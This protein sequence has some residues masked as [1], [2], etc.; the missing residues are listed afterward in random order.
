V[1]GPHFVLV[2]E[3]PPR[4]EALAD[5]LKRRYEPDYQVISMSS[6]SDALAMLAGLGQAGA[7]VALLIA[8][9]R[10]AEM[11]AADFLA[12]A[13][14]LHSRAKRVLLIHRG[15]WSPSHPTVLALAQGQ[16]DYHLLGPWSAGQRPGTGRGFRFHRQSMLYREVNEFLA[17]WEE[18][19]EPSTPAFQI[20]GPAHSPRAHRLR[21]VL[22]R[23][24]VPYRFLDDDSE[25]GQRLLREIGMEGADLPVASFYDGTVL[26][27]PSTADL[28]GALGFH[29]TVEPDACDVVIV[30]GG[31]AGMASAVCAAS[32]GLATTV[33]DPM[34]GGQA[35]TS[36]LIRNYP[37]FPHGVAGGELT[38]RLIQQAWLFGANIVVAAAA[39]LR[40]SGR[41]RVV[42]T[43]DGAPATARAVIIATGVTWRRLGIPALEALVG[44]GV[45][46]GSAAA[47]TRAC[48]GQHVF[49]I[50]AG[51]S[52]GQAAISVAKYAA[53]VTLLVRG[54]DLHDSMSQYLITETCKTGN[55]TVRPA[56]EIIDGGGRGRLETLTLRHRQTGATEVVPASVLF[57]MIG[58]EPHTDWL[59]DSVAR[60][61][62]GFI[63]TGPDLATAD[64]ARRWPLERPPLLLETSMPGVF[65]AGDVRHQSAKRVTTAIGEGA[66]AIQLLHQHRQADQDR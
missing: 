63:L 35:G 48:E 43:G 56:T 7:E 22:S 44:A 6:A 52:A 30:G 4:L 57:V 66:L 21:D 27:D 14:E 26:A 9:E 2:S 17:D 46:Y 33:L 61:D 55:I 60:D 19:R 20:V 39:G 49:V 38:V 45:Y 58:T 32:E 54:H 8:D 64:Q 50:G 3:D 42:S 24:G 11:P 29:T 1:Q 12:R 37:G 34:P 13:H 51:N 16:I 25:Q 47:E 36:P 31:P 10:L 23:V 59:E 62:Q 15:D 18:S 41:D 53:S 65:A 40:A 5:S 28:L